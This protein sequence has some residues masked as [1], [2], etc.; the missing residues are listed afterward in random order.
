MCEASTLLEF[1]VCE[2]RV[3]ELESAEQSRVAAE[4]FITDDVAPADQARCVCE[5]G[6]AHLA[7]GRSARTQLTRAERIAAERGLGPESFVGVAIAR[8]RQAMEAFESGAPL[9][10]GECPDDLPE[11]LRRWL[12]GSGEES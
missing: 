11:G 2:R 1:A 7:R 9:L 6:H 5:A 4:A 8:L 10:N 3:G 12:D